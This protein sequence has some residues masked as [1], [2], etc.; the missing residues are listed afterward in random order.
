MTNS[1]N[2][3]LNNLRKEHLRKFDFYSG[4]GT[5]LP[6]SRC[7]ILLSKPDVPFEFRTSFHTFM[8]ST[9]HV[10]IIYILKIITSNR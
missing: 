4:E 8:I 2:D 6:T 5:Y 7:E 10:L 9:N 1:Y 3:A